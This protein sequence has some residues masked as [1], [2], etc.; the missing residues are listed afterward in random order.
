[1]SN[2]NLPRC[3]TRTPRETRAPRDA[4]LPPVAYSENFWVVVGTAAPIIALASVLSYT[5]SL[6]MSGKFERPADSSEQELDRL[7]R[8]GSTATYWLWA[9]SGLN[10]IIQ[11]SALT[12]ALIS[13]ADGGN[14]ISPKI[15]ILVPG[16]GFALLAAS[17]SLSVRTRSLDRRLREAIKK[18]P[19]AP[20]ASQSHPNPAPQPTDPPWGQDSPA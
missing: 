10:I 15:V 4:R 7:R 14:D 20:E 9:L 3:C 11:G 6:G 12:L 1:M 17:S 19:K 5:E 8:Q 18:G 16:V 13:L 2:P